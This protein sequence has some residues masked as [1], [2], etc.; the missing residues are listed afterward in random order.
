MCSL[1]D[2]NDSLVR[3]VMF[4]T[5]TYLVNKSDMY[6]LIICYNI[7]SGFS[8]R[9]LSPDIVV[10]PVVLIRKW[11]IGIFMSRNHLLLASNRNLI[12][13]PSHPCLCH[14]PEVDLTL[15]VYLIKTLLCQLPPF[16]AI[17]LKKGPLILWSIDLNNR[18]L[19]PSFSSEGY[20]LC[21]QLYNTAISGCGALLSD[22]FTWFRMVA[23]R[24]S[25]RWSEI[26]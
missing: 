6:G 11:R 21:F 13:L 3:V 23:L 20:L 24:L 2:V 18:D 15:Y 25:R 26:W 17:L 7:L 5:G 22:S 19:L 1:L 14:S 12:F 10:F 9:S 16:L 4:T 8:S